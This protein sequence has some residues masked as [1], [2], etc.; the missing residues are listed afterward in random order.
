MYRNTDG[1]NFLKSLP[2]KSIDG[3]FTDPPWGGGVKIMGNDKPMDLMRA[4][5]KE[6]PRILK[7]GA[8]VL[9]WIGARQLADFIRVFKNLEYRWM[10]VCQY[11]PARYI[12]KFQAQ[13]DPILYLSLPGEPYPNPEKSLPQIYQ[14]VSSG[15]RDTLHPCSRP[16]KVV[17]KIIRDWFRPGEYIIDPFAGSDTVGVACREIAIQADTCEIDPK[18]YEYGQK[19]NSQGFLFESVETERCK[20]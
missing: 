6:C 15:R 19:R 5:D 12:I 18:M 11:I 10:I 13:L 1:L 7:P 8:R 2:D 16:I 3:I 14:K 4:L 9:I 17:R 20:I